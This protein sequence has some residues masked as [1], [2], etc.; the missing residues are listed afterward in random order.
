MK[1]FTSYKKQLIIQENILYKLPASFKDQFGQINMKSIIEAAKFDP[2]T[3]SKKNINEI[4]AGH[5]KS[6]PS[7]GMDLSYI[8]L[9]KTSSYFE[10]L[11]SNLISWILLKSPET[12]PQFTNNMSC[13]SLE[14]TTQLQIRK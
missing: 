7:L 3:K 12:S 8:N 11:N 13:L 6:I 10:Y 1:F 2:E 4:K 9:N 5:M 14:G